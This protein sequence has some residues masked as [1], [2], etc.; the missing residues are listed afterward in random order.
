MLNTPGMGDKPIA[1]DQV[2]QVP[3]EERAHGVLRG[4]HDGL[5]V[6]VEAGVDDRRAAGPRGDAI[7]EE[8]AIPEENAPQEDPETEVSEPADAGE[9]PPSDPR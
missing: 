4:C 6:H 2:V 3:L 5:F 7:P 1:Q 9:V 8:A